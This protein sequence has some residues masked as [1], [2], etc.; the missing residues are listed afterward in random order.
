MRVKSLLP[1]ALLF[2]LQPVSAAGNQVNCTIGPVQRNFGDAT[3]NLYACD[4]SK[5]VVVVPANAT[6]DRT[7]YFFVTPN[8]D[9]KTKVVVVGE[10]WGKDQELKPVF[11]ELQ[12][13]SSTDLWLTISIARTTS[14]GN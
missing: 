13:M 9:D 10:G 11:D 12:Q 14:K 5:S 1:I 7:G 3:W 6:S 8:P 2:L 4:D